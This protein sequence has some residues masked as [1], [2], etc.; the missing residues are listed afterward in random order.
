MT[1]HAQHVLRTGN[2]VL[3]IPPEE[4]F[5][6]FSPEGERTWVPDWTPEYLHPTDGAPLPGLVFRTRAGGELTLWLVVRYDPKVFEAEYVRLAPDS[7]LGTVVVRCRGVAGD[8]T[9]VEVTY[10]L[11]AVSDAGNLMLASLT[12]GAYAKMLTDWQDRI[13]AVLSDP[14]PGP[15]PSDAA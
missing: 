8:H 11:T 2:F 6:F 9:Q 5:S 10:A 14:A 12:E 7:R 13:T 15:A 3:P 1:F 4:A